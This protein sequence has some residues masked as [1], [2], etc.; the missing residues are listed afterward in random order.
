MNSGKSQSLVEYIGIVAVVA[1]LLLLVYEIRQN[2]LAV[3][4]T[5]LQQHCPTHQ[6]DPGEA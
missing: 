2:T 1:S 3:Q 4:S 6:F 5:A